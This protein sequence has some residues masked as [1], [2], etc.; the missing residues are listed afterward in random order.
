[1]SIASTFEGQKVDKPLMREQGG[2]LIET[3]PGY[4][5]WSFPDGSLLEIGPHTTREVKSYGP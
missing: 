1:M 2:R 5:L 3:I 4:E